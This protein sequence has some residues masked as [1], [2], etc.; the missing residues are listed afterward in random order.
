[1]G[2][3]TT[4]GVAQARLLLMTPL[5]LPGPISAGLN[6]LTYSLPVSEAEKM[7]KREHLQ[8]PC[9]AVMSKPSR[10]VVGTVVP[11]VT[12]LV[13]NR[14]TQCMTHAGSSLLPS[15]FN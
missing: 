7:S 13:L 2:R 15:S 5:A 4:A 1:M 10:E 9:T 14:T 6:D 8:T 12:A 11:A 3:R